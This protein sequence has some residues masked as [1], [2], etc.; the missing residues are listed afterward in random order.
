MLIFIIKITKGFCLST[1]NKQLHI[2]SNETKMSIDS[3]D[4]VTPSMYKSLFT[5]FALKHRESL[6]DEEQLSSEL[7]NQE[8]SQLGQMQEQT[9]KNAIKLSAHT[10]KAIDAIEKKDDAVL[11]K[12]LQE[13]QNLRAEIEKLKESVYKDELTQA[14]N[15]KWFHDT[16]LEDENNSFKEDGICVMIDLNYFKQINDTHGHVIGD[17]V[18]VFITNELK[19]SK[20]KIVR[21]G[22][23]EFIII[24]NTQFSQEFV[25]KILHN[26]RENILKKKLKAQE[27]TFHVSFSV[28]VTH[29][30]KGEMFSQVL[31]LADKNM[32]EDKLQIK[33]RVT[34]I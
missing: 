26:I 17:K 1:D 7:M 19:K 30:E 6:E 18:L 21:Y 9:S 3:M 33:K 5:E 25:L 12:V 16:Y 11:K 31:E 13:T 32:Y 10:A 23:D 8:C 27:A 14:Y 15:R 34:G 4:V 20:Q 24:F 2:I 22:G 28:G 29:F